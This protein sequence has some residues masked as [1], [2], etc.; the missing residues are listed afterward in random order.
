MNQQF[1]G[2]PKRVQV[3]LL[4]VIAA[5]AN[6]QT[7]NETDNATKTEILSENV[8]NEEESG[9]RITEP[10][11]DFMMSESDFTRYCELVYARNLE[12][13][14]DSGGVGNTFWDA[15]KA[16]YDAEDAYI[17]AVAIDIPQFTPEQVSRLKS[18]PKWR[19]EFFRITGI[20]KVIAG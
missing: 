3:A 12:K 16:V 18:S 1:I 10:F 11:G 13:G 14:M 4:K 15:H 7:V 20:E 8:F 9:E 17:D 5:R 2:M 19:A 6:W